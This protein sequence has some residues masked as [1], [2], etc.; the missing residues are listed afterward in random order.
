MTKSDILIANYK[1]SFWRG[2]GEKINF[3]I[4]Y[5]NGWYVF[6]DE[7]GGET[8]IRGRYREKDIKNMI[9]VLE[10]R[11]DERRGFTQNISILPTIIDEVGDYVTRDGGKVT[12]DKIKDKSTSDDATGYLWQEFRGKFVPR[13]FGIW[14]VSGRKYSLAESQNDIIG[15][16]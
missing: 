15:K 3:S 9:E 2:N 13:R 11:G 6:F 1:M 5:R 14:H 7:V 4:E 12:I 16:V 8:L 10:R